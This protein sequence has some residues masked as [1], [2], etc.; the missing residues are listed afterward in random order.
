M[1]SH[2]TVADSLN[3]PDW[4][5]YGLAEI[6]SP[7]WLS[8]F[9]GTP[10]HGADVIRVDYR[11]YGHPQRLIVQSDPIRAIGDPAPYPDVD[12]VFD[13]LRAE[14]DDGTPLPVVL[15]GT[16]EEEQDA[17]IP[18]SAD[19]TPFPVVMDGR[20]AYAQAYTDG[21]NHLYCTSTAFLD[22][23]ARPASMITVA[24]RNFALDRIVLERIHD[25]GPAKRERARVV[26][27][28]LQQL[29]PTPPGRGAG[30]GH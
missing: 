4:P 28:I 5:L 20:P 12:A 25:L 1:I 9:A 17:E 6:G 14:D 8:G 23:W 16:G 29:P 10:L 7:G 19:L 2:V 26:A 3:L 22:R 24:T 18:R 13:R 27:D 15:T 11:P 30:E 21:N